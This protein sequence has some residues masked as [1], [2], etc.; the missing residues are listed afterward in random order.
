MAQKEKNER[1]L[2]SVKGK[3]LNLCVDEKNKKTSESKE[4]KNP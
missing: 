4:K 2:C 3:I 1:K